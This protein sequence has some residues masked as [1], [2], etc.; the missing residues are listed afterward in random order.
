M[1]VG[2]LQAEDQELEVHERMS[3]DP[4]VTGIELKSSERIVQSRDEG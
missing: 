4:E 2:S 3:Q 1:D